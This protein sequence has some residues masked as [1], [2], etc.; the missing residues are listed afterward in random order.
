M[1]ADYTLI[2]AIQGKFLTFMYF[3]THPNQCINKENI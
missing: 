1:G 3:D 2:L